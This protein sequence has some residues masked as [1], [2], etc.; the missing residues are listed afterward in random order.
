MFS[1]G[2]NIDKDRSASLDIKLIKQDNDDLEKLV[3][4]EDQAEVNKSEENLP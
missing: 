1:S 4:S 3:P 2:L